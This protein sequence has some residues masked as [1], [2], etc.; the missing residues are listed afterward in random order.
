MAIYPRPSS[1]HGRAGAFRLITL[2][3][4]FHHRNPR[5]LSAGPSVRVSWIIPQ[6]TLSR[7]TGDRRA[8]KGAARGERT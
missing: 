2:M 8:V 4:P 3:N 5:C 6:S 7:D 1:V